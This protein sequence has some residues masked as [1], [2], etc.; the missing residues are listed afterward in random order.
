MKK[1]LLSNLL[2]LSL[3][4]A[5]AQNFEGSISTTRIEDDQ[6]S[7][8]IWYFKDGKMSVH[9]SITDKTGTYK[10]VSVP[11]LDSKKLKATIE[12]KDGSHDYTIPVK[13]IKANPRVLAPVVSVSTPVESKD[14]K[15]GNIKTVTINTSEGSIEL[16]VCTDVNFNLAPYSDYFKGDWFIKA[17]AITGMVGFPVKCITYDLSGNVLTTVTATEIN[18]GVVSKSKF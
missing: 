16:S 12:G 13:E 10:F 2:I 18:P 17:V 15:F 14:A 11:Q 8:S 7:E 6:T 5:Y 9:S 3:V 1:I 4:T